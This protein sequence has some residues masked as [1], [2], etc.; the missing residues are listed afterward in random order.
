MAANL[1]LAQ[2]EM[3]E[4][5]FPLQEWIFHTKKGTRLSLGNARR[6]HL[7]PAA[8][9][10]SVKIGGWHDFTNSKSVPRASG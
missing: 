5:R 1:V 9:A 3:E 2:R 6:R 4:E 8:T 7:H 10:I